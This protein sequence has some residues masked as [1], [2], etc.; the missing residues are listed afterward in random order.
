MAVALDLKLLSQELKEAGSPWEMDETTDMALMTEDERRKRLGFTPPPGEM[1]FEQAVALCA[2]LKPM[3][4]AEIAADAIGAPSAYDLRNV[5]GKDFTTRVKDQGG[6]GSCVAFGTVAVMETT[7]RRRANDPNLAVDL[8]EAHLFYCH[9]AEEGRNCGNGWWPDN[10]FRKAREKGIAFDSFFPYTAG[11]QACQVQSGWKDNL[12]KVT[13]HSKM[14]SRADMKNWISTRG[15]LTGCF[16]V[17]QDFFSYRS[18]VY[19]HVSGEAAGGHCVEIL[20]YDDS[21][22]CWICKNSWGTNWGEGGYFRIAYGQ[23]NIETWAGPYGA[24]AVTLRSWARNTKVR[25]LWTNRSDR[26]AHVHL[27]GNGWRKVADNNTTVQHAMLAELIA[28]KAGARRVDALVEN[29]KI[30]QVY[31]I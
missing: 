12:A 22:G 30:Q 3:T 21:Q 1:Q 31:V 27:A 11:N 9:A 17:Y 10:A 20:G 26:N 19:R 5:G 13:G 25:A 29:N 28:A 24:N 23:A 16:I 14:S 8:S 4:A 6:C 7:A 18:G 2:T 15:S